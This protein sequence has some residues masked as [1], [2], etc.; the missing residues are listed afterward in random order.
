M[1]FVTDQAGRAP[2]DI[3][4]VAHV[5][6]VLAEK[7]RP[8]EVFEEKIYCS[9]ATPLALPAPRFSRLQGPDRRRDPRFEA[10]AWFFRAS[11]IRVRRLEGDCCAL[12]SHGV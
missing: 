10:A 1:S 8:L 11:A 2:E 12:A 9:S 6:T 5:A 7:H 4:R 3:R